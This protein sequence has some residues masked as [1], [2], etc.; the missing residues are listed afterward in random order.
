[1]F[2]FIYFSIIS[3]GTL[4]GRGIGF[5]AALIIVATIG[6]LIEPNFIGEKYEP[7]YFDRHA[8]KSFELVIPEE[9]G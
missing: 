3:I 5:I 7:G 4:V 2:G 6:L 1:M 8:A 9:K